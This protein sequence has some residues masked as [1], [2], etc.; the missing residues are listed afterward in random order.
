MGVKID[1]VYTGNLHC[2]L[3]HEPSGAALDTDAPKDNEGQGASYA[4]TDLVS[5]ALVSCALTTMAI[6]A[7][8]AGVPFPGAKGRIEKTMSTDGPRHIESLRAV[9]ELPAGTPAEHR[10]ALEEFAATC[11]VALTLGEQVRI[12]MV[13]DYNH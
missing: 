8:R 12:D 3:Y 1:A 10:Q 2:R 4:P 6:R 5:A 13:F 9:F 7:R 11:P